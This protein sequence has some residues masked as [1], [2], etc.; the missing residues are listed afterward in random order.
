MKKI[1]MIVIKMKKISEDDEKIQINKK[2]KNLIGKIGKNLYLTLF[3]N[4]LLQ[5]D[6]NFIFFGNLN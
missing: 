1:V 5:L 2:V 6:N 3:D 4:I